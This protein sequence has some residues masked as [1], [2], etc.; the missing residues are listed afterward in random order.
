MNESFINSKIY[1]ALH[2][3]LN[4]GLW[5]GIALSVVFIILTIINPFLSENNGFLNSGIC[6]DGFIITN[7]ILTEMTEVNYLLII[8]SVIVPVFGILCIWMLRNIINSLRNGSPF[9]NENVKRIRIIGWVIFAYTY[10]NQ[11]INY[12]YIQNLYDALIN[13]GIEPVFKANFTIIPNGVI[14][15]FCILV[16]AEIFRYGCI[17]QQEHDTT[18]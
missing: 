13:E 5:I 17:L 12:F 4:A 18:V 11:I 6:F 16:L 9:T 10:L 2:F 15:A 7:D 8:M 3:I 1:K 14:L